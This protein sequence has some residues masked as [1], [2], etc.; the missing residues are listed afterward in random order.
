MAD[1]EDHYSRQMREKINQAR[2]EV[3]NI[4]A[5]ISKT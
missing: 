1:S 2:L 4:L 3:E 5:E